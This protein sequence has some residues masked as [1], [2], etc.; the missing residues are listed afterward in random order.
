MANIKSCFRDLAT[1]SKPN[2][3]AI[4]ITSL[5]CFNFNYSDPSIL[6]TDLKL[7]FYILLSINF[8]NSALVKAPTLVASTS[9]FLNSIS[10]GIPRTP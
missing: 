5:I 2:D 7:I 6:Q 9:P 3:S 10:V 1:F 8:A 4:S